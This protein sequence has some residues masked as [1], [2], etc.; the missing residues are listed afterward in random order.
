MKLK[1]VCLIL[2][3]MGSVFS[4]SAQNDFP[5]EKYISRTL[6][7]IGD[8]NLALQNADK[9][10]KDAK[11][12]VLIFD[13]DFLYSHVRVKFMNKSRS[14]SAERKELLGLWQKTFGLD[15]KAIALYESEYLFKECNTEHWIPYQK[16][17]AAFFP[18]ELKEGDMVTLYLMRA[19]GKKAKDS[20]IWD[21]IYLGNEFVK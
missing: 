6:A 5:Y 15:E 3:V 2:L 13:A 7:E 19:S 8:L 20:N 10:I 21:W 11:A 12:G 16:Q 14:M 18:K 17:V 1:I 4:V 9:G